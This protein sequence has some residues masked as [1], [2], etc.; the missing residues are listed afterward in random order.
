MEIL[1]PPSKP[2]IRFMMMLVT[3]DREHDRKHPGMSAAR[4]RVEAEMPRNKADDD[5]GDRGRDQDAGTG[6]RCDQSAGIGARVT[7]STSRSIVIRPTAAAPAASDPE[8]A[9]EHAADEHR[10]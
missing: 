1:P 6:A 5:I 3:H 4:N 7:L 8:I 9:G 2:W 10:C